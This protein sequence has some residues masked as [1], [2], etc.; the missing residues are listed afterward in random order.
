MQKRAQRGSREKL[1]A[2]LDKAPDLEPD[3]SDKL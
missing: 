3:E 2:V 1:L